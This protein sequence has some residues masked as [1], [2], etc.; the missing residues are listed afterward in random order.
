MES[1]HHMQQ[2]TIF[3][4]RIDEAINKITGVDGQTLMEL[5]DEIR[6][7]REHLENLERQ[8]ED[9]GE[10]ICATISAEIRKL[11]PKVE[12]SISMSRCNIKYKARSIVIKPDLKKNEF[13]ILPGPTVA[14]TRLVKEF[15]KKWNGASIDKL[16]DLVYDAAILFVGK[17]KTLQ[18]GRVDIPDDEE[19]VPEDSP[20]FNDGT[21]APDLGSR[22][23][24]EDPG[25]AVGSAIKRS[26]VSKSGGG[27][28]Y[29]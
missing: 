2:Q 23:E 6:A 18:G 15:A 24:G 7:A 10:E 11:L 12:V 19:E 29:A 8:L 13:R 1:R 3:E 28:Q 25:P 17:Y 20:E 5:L 21:Q 22:I 4:R 14:D 9:H 27:S 26:G 16:S